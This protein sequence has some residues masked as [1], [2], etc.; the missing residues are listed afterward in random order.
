LGVVWDLNGIGE[1]P[2]GSME[3]ERIKEPLKPT[4]AA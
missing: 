2:Y 1:G 4:I 3:F